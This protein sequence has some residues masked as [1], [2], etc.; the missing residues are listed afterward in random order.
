MTGIGATPTSKVE[1]YL[2][3]AQGEFLAFLER[4][5]LAESPNRVKRCPGKQSWATGGSRWR[6]CHHPGVARVVGALRAALV[7]VALWV[8]SG[9]AQADLLFTITGTPGSPLLQIAGSGS[10]SGSGGAR[11]SAFVTLTES[12]R[13]GSNPM[14]RGRSSSRRRSSAR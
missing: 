4:L 2:F 8:P 7:M 13:A 11:K 12:P 5:T 9:N 1:D 3:G 10:G 6:G 14:G